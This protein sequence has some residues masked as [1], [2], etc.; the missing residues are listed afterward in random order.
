MSV[1][2]HYIHYVSLMLLGLMTGKVT[3]SGELC[4]K[5]G[6]IGNGNMSTMNKETH[7]FRNT[8]NISNLIF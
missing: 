5:Q 1:I 2:Y 6:I 4:L 3:V 7:N 8:H